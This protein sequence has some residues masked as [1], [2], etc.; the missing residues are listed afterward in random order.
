MSIK[1]HN[2]KYIPGDNLLISD[3][4][5]RVIR[6]SE[7]RTQWDGLVVH[8]SEWEPRHPQD[9]IRT[10]PEN[11]A[12]PEPRRPP[13]DDGLCEPIFEAGVFEPLVFL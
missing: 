6:R 12:A 8:E 9:L 5:G 13:T 4:S 2:S 1:D 7:S 11:I 10:K 3:R